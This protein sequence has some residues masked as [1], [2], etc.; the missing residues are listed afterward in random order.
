[1][2]PRSVQEP[3]TI[4]DGL[5]PGSDGTVTRHPAF[6]QIAA[7]RVS[8]GGPGVPLYG[9]DFNHQ[10]FVTITVRTSEERRDLSHYWHHG[11]R[12]LIEVN[13]SEAQWAT[14]VSS[15]NVGMGV[16]CT[17]TFQ[18]AEGAGPVPE[19][20]LRDT[21]K[22][23]NEELTAKVAKMARL[24]QEAM[25]EAEPLLEGLSAKKRAAVMAKLHTVHQEAKSNLPFVAKSFAEHIEKTV[26][27]AK[28][29]VN[30]YI[31]HAVVSAGLQALQNDAIL[32][33]G[34][35]SESTPPQLMSGEPHE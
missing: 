19:I 17:L 28:I 10:H 30:A 29:E 12:E 1:M 23:F 5:T 11:G 6:A 7:S 25:D 2:S 9:S 27:K 8:A 24:L 4:Q 31:N 21:E 3:V 22:V 32:T 26:E 16:P 33:L 18:A 34:R 15:M 20:T 14:F 13:L 35:P